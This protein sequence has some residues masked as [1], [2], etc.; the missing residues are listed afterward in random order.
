MSRYS[1]HAIH[2]GAEQTARYI[3][4]WKEPCKSCKRY[5]QEMPLFLAQMSVNECYECLYKFLESVS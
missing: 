5:S 3:N 1:A 4:K 2:W